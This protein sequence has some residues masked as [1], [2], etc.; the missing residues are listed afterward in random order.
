VL[1]KF[2]FPKRITAAPIVG[3]AVSCVSTEAKYHTG[4]RKWKYASVKDNI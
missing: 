2:H 3:A 1:N 4:I